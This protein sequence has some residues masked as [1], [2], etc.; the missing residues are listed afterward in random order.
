MDPEAGVT[1]SPEPDGGAAA[2]STV[3]ASRL[4]L[5]FVSVAAAVWPGASS[6]EPGVVAVTAGGS[7]A[8]STAKTAP[9]VG[10]ASTPV[11]STAVFVL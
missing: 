7:A 5:V 11:I 2:H 4:V 3:I 6:S 10:C 8:N 1:V 9:S